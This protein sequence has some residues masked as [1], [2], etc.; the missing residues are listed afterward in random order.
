MPYLIDMIVRIH[1]QVTDI[2][3]VNLCKFQRECSHLFQR[4]DRPV[5]FKWKWK[6]LCKNFTTW[7]N[8]KL[9]QWMHDSPTTTGNL[10]PTTLCIGRIV[11]HLTN[12]INYSEMLKQMSTLPCKDSYINMLLI[13]EWSICVLTYQPSHETVN[14]KVQH[15]GVYVRRLPCARVTQH[16]CD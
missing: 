12:W 13:A 1:Y 10:L 11:L 4:G 5:S 9:E 3:F 2:W 16:T 7:L 6:I 15:D 14:W 8:V